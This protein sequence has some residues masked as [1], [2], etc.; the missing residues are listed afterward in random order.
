MSEAP[1]NE[2]IG[3]CSHGNLPGIC[4]E[5]LESE[6]GQLRREDIRHE[7]GRMGSDIAK[8]LWNDLEM[9]G[10]VKPEEYIYDVLMVLGAGYREPDPDFGK[11][12]LTEGKEPNASSRLNM[13][14]RMRL[15]AAAQMYL[16]GRT[17]LIC[18]TGG[19]AISEKWQ[20]MPALAELAKQY[21]TEKFD[22]PEGDII[23]ENLSDATHGNLA[24]GLRVMYRDN[25]PVGRFAILSTNYHL[26]RAR[27]M[28]KRSGIE[29]D[30]IPA[31]SQ[32][33][34]RSKH[35]R[36]LVEEWLV[37][38]QN[39]GLEENEIAKLQDSNYWEKRS[40]I[41]TTPLDQDVPGVDV[42]GDVAA[43]AARLSAAGTVG[44]QT[45]AF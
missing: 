6:S 2:K 28:A 5:C 3:L 43:T 42:S 26:N 8:R 21:L 23:L 45:D 22:I 16:E 41:F 39:A 14:F 31:E 32:L 27:E 29:A 18:L 44:I 36:K 1:S 10:G 11:T 33:L 7:A 25:I 9:K 17:R 35:Y 37:R 13:E 12:P 20:Q 30:F 15:N 24:H 4:K 40:A 38:A 19:L 34:R